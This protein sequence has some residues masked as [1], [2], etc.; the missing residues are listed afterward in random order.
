MRAAATTKNVAENNLINKNKR[1]AE[2]ALTSDK[3]KRSAF[4]DLTNAISKNQDAKK[5]AKGKTISISTLGRA[6]LTRPTTKPAVPTVKEEVKVPEP[7]VEPEDTIY[8]SPENCKPKRLLPPNVEDFDSECGNDPFQTPQYAQ[9][10]FL[11]FKEREVLKFF[12]HFNE[13]S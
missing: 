4:G 12:S 10:I 3:Q 1:K 13:T 8:F 5:A 7:Q 11:Y 2:T 6:Q 9:D